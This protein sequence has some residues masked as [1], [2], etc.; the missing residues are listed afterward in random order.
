MPNVGRS[1]EVSPVKT[2]QQKPR[3]SAT[4]GIR[5]IYVPAHR[6]SPLRRYW[7]DLIRPLVEHMC[8]QVRMNLRRRCV[9]LRIQPQKE[10]ECNLK[11]T[12]TA[13]TGVVTSPT[14]EARQTTGIVDMK[15]RSL[16]DSGWAL[17]KGAEYVK[18]FMLGFDVR[19]TVA[20][21]RLE[22]LFV[23]S[24]EIHDVKKLNGAHLS[25]CIGRLSGHQ[26]RT[27]HAIENAT[28]TRVVIADR[29]IHIL[30]AFQN[31]QI[32]KHAISS[33]IMGSPPG[34]VYNHLRTAAKRLSERL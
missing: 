6:Y 20:L 14:T 17:E 16:R 7:A 31:I 27:K 13:I 3:P 4:V 30:G 1:K 18:A 11:H 8:L 10:D 21:L 24:F 28:R 15:I 5:R 33:L 19:D 23:E 26:G 34:K 25:R 2:R 12:T 9:E 22:D 29:K 32:A